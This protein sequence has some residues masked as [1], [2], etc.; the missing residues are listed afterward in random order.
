MTAK[1]RLTNQV[2]EKLS[3]PA[4][5][6]LEIGDELCPGL[7]VRVTEGGAKSFSAIYRVLGE[8]GETESG[9]LLAGKQHRI[10]LGRWP[11][12]GLADARERTRAIIAK[13]GAG[14][15]PRAAVVSE[16]REKRANT[17]SAVLDRHIQQDA[18]RNISSWKNVER[19]LRLHVVPELGGRPISDIRR[20][21]V[22]E[23]IDHLVSSGRIGTAREVRKHLSRIF[24]W[25][26]DREIIDHN[27]INGMKRLDLARNTE[28]GRSLSA[29]EI[30][31][32]WR[33]TEELRYPFGTL[34]QT[35][36]MKPSCAR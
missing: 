21:D 16:I 8:G 17:F 18:T 13:A 36:T 32:V 31:A 23:I 22:H 34:Y 6:R 9:R 25:A 4:G 26:V 30:R 14:S 33:A 2:L 29:A 15:D 11:I 7:V 28:A 19:V 1:K 3:A 5:T 35:P 27:P 12:V 10:T 20:A 24:N